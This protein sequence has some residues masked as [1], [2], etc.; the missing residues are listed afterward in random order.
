LVLD[1][2]QTDVNMAVDMDIARRAAVFI[3]NGVGVFFCDF[4]WMGVFF[5]DGLQFFWALGSCLRIWS[6]CL[7]SLR[8]FFLSFTL[9]P[10]L[11]RSFLFLLSFVCEEGGCLP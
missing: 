2:E 3:G 5:L 9:R 11:L 8:S 4:F 10:W 6:D 7:P 1:Q